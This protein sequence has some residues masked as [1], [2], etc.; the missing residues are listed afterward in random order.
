MTDI[1]IEKPRTLGPT[2][3]D[4][5][6]KAYEHLLEVASHVDPKLT[7]VLQQKYEE[8]RREFSQ[9][10][11]DFMPSQDPAYWAKRGCSKCYGRGIIGKRHVFMPGESAQAVREDGEK[12]YAN[13]ITTFD[14]QCRCTQKNFKKWMSDFRLF[15]NMLKAQ[16]IAEAAQKA[17]EQED[18]A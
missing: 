13:S 10:A 6:D 2:Q 14:K 5:A 11:R 4:M 7:E 1:T 18:G 16:T 12:T 15:F 17:G 3:L 9:A 8:D